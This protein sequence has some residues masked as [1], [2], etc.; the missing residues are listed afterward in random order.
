MPVNNKALALVVVLALVFIG[1]VGIQFVSVGKANPFFWMDEVPPDAYTEPPVVS[2]LSPKNGTTYTGNVSLTFNVTIGESKTAS[3]AVIFYVQ[4]YADWQHNNTDYFYPKDFHPEGFP[5]QF[6]YEMNLTGIPE[7]NH[8]IRV[9]AIERGTYSLTTA[10]STNSS[11][12]V[13]FSIGTPEPEIQ[14]S[15]PAPFPATWLIAA[16]AT[17]AV[18][19]AAFTLYYTKNRK[20]TLKNEK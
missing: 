20:T 2:I 14:Q 16:V 15:E 11:S 18:G 1:M 17:I 9:Y 4:Y 8:S 5:T 3:E 6:S 7:G 13:F 19:G 12:T 10:F